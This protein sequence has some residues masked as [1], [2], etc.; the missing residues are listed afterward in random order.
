M[1]TCTAA[2]WFGSRENNYVILVT[3]KKQQKMFL[4]LAIARLEYKI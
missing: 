4:R 3:L 2:V 1:I